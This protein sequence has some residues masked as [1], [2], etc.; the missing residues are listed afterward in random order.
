MTE[1]SSSATGR[2]RQPCDRIFCGQS[3]G[4]RG[5]SA[6][7][8]TPSLRAIWPDIVVGL[9]IAFTNLDAARKVWA[10]ARDEHRLAKAQ[11]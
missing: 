5:G 3:S 10:A 7:I 1:A 9:G 8:V 11:A 2:Y 4:Q 6:G